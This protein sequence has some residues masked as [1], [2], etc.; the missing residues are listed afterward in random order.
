MLKRLSNLGAAIGDSFYRAGPAGLLI[1]LTAGL[2]AAFAL[3]PRSFVVEL[4]S[5]VII[6]FGYLFAL[7]I[8][9][10]QLSCGES[11]V[12]RAANLKNAAPFT[13][14]VFSA[15]VL[16]GA[17]VYGFGDELLKLFATYPKEAAGASLAVLL[18]SLTILACSIHWAIGQ[19][20]FTGNNSTSEIVTSR[21][22]VVPAMMCLQYSQ[23]DRLRR[24]AH[25]AGQALCFASSPY[26]DEDFDFTED[27]HVLQITFRPENYV[28]DVDDAWWQLFQL[29]AA[30]QA[31]ITLA[32]PKSRVSWENYASIERFATTVLVADLGGSKSILDPQS[33]A[34]LHWKARRIRLLVKDLMPKVRQ[35]LL[36]NKAPLNQLVELMQSGE[37]SRL[38]LF[39]ILDEVDTRFLPMPWKPEGTQHPP[40]RVVKS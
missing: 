39:E 27:G 29:L 19:K 20:P 37:L 11:G 33:E 9:L 8:T 26:L 24:A 14:L 21:T 18:L 23:K 2:V 6:G 5:G 3:N 7:I 13:Y 36:A 17:A 4:T 16:V 31:E 40:L 25:F 28:T 34:E 32:K 30:E 38:T 12:E 15:C 1:L 10:Y 22:E 35:F